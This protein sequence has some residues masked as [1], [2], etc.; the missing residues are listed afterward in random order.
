MLL[1]AL[2]EVITSHVIF[3]YRKREG[4]ICG[5]TRSLKSVCSV[6]KMQIKCEYLKCSFNIRLGILLIFQF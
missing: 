4:S 5:N 6:E 1:N 2:K 3:N